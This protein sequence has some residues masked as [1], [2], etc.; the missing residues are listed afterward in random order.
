MLI[1]REDLERIRDGRITHAFRRWRRPS[2]RSGGTLLTAIGQLRLSSVSTVPEGA[3][4]AEDAAD[5]GY[6]SLDDLLRDLNRHREGEIYR[7]AFGGVAADP[8]VALRES[9]PDAAETGAVLTRLARLDL[10]SAAPWTGQV[11]EIIARQPGVRAEVLARE[12]SMDKTNFKSRVRTLKGLG[13]T[14]CLGTGYRISPRGTAV[15]SA[16][17]EN[18][19]RTS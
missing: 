4:T 11:L 10:R 3:L 6:S 18:R 15:L 19:D 2:A 9:V 14:I 16:V 8:R 5:A 17:L 13:L 7:I 12:T 1:R